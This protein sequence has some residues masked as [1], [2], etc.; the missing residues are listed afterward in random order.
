[1]AIVRLYFVVHLACSKIKSQVPDLHHI[2]LL[3]MLRLL[4][5]GVPAA[6]IAE[7]WLCLPVIAFAWYTYD[8]CISGSCGFPL[9]QLCLSGI[10]VM[11]SVQSA[12]LPP[13]ASPSS[14]VAMP[15]RASSSS[16]HSL[17]A[18]PSPLVLRRGATMTPDLGQTKVKL[19]DDQVDVRS[20]YE[21]RKL[22]LQ[23]LMQQ[24]QHHHQAC[25]LHLL[26]SL[27]HHL[28]T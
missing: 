6:T 10:E 15:S 18:T 12:S 16:S 21:S 25:I 3:D 9:Q 13:P 28:N 1:M 19:E 22:E 14:K 23:K 27:M 11:S 4:L 26:V 17:V 24:K 20:Y 7:V 2:N 8:V 5:S